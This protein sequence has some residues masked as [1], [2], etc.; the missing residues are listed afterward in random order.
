MRYGL[1]SHF[2]RGWLQE[3]GNNEFSPSSEKFQQKSQIFLFSVGY[4]QLCYR[5]PGRVLTKLNG[6]AGSSTIV[7]D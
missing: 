3:A 1:T 5:A 4:S 2:W 7:V 6:I